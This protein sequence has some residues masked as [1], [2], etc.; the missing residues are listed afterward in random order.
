M[1]TV[2]IYGKQWLTNE[3]IDDSWGLIL[4]FDGRGCD[5]LAVIVQKSYDSLSRTDG[6]GR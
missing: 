4:F 6:A 3:S 2:A 1:K 5:M